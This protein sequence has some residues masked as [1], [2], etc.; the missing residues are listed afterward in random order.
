MCTH[1]TPHIIS[2]IQLGQETLTAQFSPRSHGAARPTQS[3]AQRKG[4]GW[5]SNM[6]PIWEDVSGQRSVARVWPIC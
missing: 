6:Y 5:A 1:Q 2:S 4:R 3:S